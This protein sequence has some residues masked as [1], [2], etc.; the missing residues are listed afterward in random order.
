MEGC[1]IFQRYIPLSDWFGAMVFNLF[2]QYKV[3][4]PENIPLWVVRHSKVTSSCHKP[5][6]SLMLR[7]RNILA[8][9]LKLRNRGVGR[10]THLW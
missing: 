5:D 7:A 2:Y 3:S 1:L 6:I 4:R 8:I 10:A 9:D